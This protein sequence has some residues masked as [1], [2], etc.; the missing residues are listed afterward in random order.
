MLR[1]IHLDAIVLDRREI[2]RNSNMIANRKFANRNSFREASP[3][4]A[5]D[6]MVAGNAYMPA[7]TRLNTKSILL[8]GWMFD[9]RTCQAQFHFECPWVE[10]RYIDPPRDIERT[11]LNRT[12]VIFDRLDVSGRVVE[13]HD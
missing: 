10:R 8:A 12:G 4:P 13:Q 6:T 3:A 1:N 5:K 11:R 7:I 9:Q 2:R